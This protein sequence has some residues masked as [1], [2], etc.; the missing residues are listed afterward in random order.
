MLNQEKGIFKFLMKFS[1]IM[2]L[3]VCWM[4]CSLPMVTLG[5]ATAALYETVL[6]CIRNDE[7]NPYSHFF[8][9][10]KRCLRVSILPTLLGLAALVFLLWL[11]RVVYVMAA[12]GQ[13]L[14]LVLV[15]GVAL[16]IALTLGVWLVAVLLA[17]RF[18]YRWGKLVAKAFKVTFGHVSAVTMV[19]VVGLFSV[20]A[21]KF[22]FL[23]ILVLPVLAMLVMSYALEPIF[24]TIS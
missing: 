7:K 20:L 2:G 10:I 17:A 1:D 4:F 22:T 23:F 6:C 15:F 14:G 8:G 11:Y 21:G 3:S 24:E 18:D 13:R 12:A 19:L 9:G 5:A 16:L